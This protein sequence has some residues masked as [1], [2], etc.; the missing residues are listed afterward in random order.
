MD[1]QNAEDYG[2]RT[3]TVKGLEIVPDDRFPNRKPRH[4][5]DVGNGED[6]HVVLIFQDLD[7]RCR[8]TS[9]PMGI[10]VFIAVVLNSTGSVL[11]VNLRSEDG[12]R[13]FLPSFY[14]RLGGWVGVEKGL[15]A[16]V[17]VMVMA[18]PSSLVYIG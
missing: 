15:V 6:W 4:G 12:G 17:A 1:E 2:C 10:Q 3:L 9:G 16:K 18:I 5:I 8:G 7:L 11:S 13:I 14:N